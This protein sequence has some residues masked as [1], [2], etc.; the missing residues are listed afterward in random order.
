M[1]L[2]TGPCNGKQ[3][4]ISSG[5]FVILVL[6]IKEPKAIAELIS[7]PQKHQRSLKSRSQRNQDHFTDAANS[8][9]KTTAQTKEV[10]PVTNSRTYQPHSKVTKEAI[11][12]K[13]IVTIGTIVVSFPQEHYHSKHPKQIRSGDDL[14]VSIN[15]INGFLRNIGE[16]YGFK[17]KSNN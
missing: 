6:G 15:T 7:T 4:R 9:S 14:L 5:I 17:K 2:D 13:N 8:T 3:W 11:T 12:S 10:T 16:K 1:L